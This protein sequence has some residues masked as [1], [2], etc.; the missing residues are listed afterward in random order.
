MASVNKVFVLGYVG[1]DPELRYTPSGIANVT[2]SV[3]TS[4]SWKSKE[5]GEKVEETEWHRIVAWDKLAEIIGEYLHKGDQ[6]HIEGRLKTRK[7]EKDGHTNYTTEIICEQMTMLGKRDKSEAAP[8]RPKS[9][10]HI[11]STSTKERQ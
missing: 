4:R 6:V 7:W 11:T 3:A 9:R 8:H 2:I 5:S 1:K 10:Y